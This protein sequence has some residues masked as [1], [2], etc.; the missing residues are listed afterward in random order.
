MKVKLKKPHSD[1]NQNTIYNVLRIEICNDIRFCLQTSFDY[2][3]IYLT[4]CYESELFYILDNAMSNWSIEIF[5]KS[6]SILETNKI[7]QVSYISIAPKEIN[8]KS[9]ECDLTMSYDAGKYGYKRYDDANNALAR[10]CAKNGKIKLTR[11]QYMDIFPEYQIA[12]LEIGKDIGEGYVICPNCGNAYN[13]KNQGVICCEN[14]CC[15]KI[16]NNPLAK[17]T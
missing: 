1:L 11:H 5:E 4:D 14:K 2:G 8:Y 10:V 17:K 9:F 7:E 16:F 15:K 6:R 13:A 12:N 3:Q